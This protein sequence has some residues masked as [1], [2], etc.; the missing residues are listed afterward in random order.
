VVA[1]PPAFRK[2]IA[3]ALLAALLRAEA[4]GKVLADAAAMRARM[5]RDHPPEGPW[6]VKHLPGGLVEVEFLAQALQ[7]A[8]G[9]P[10]AT[11]TAQALAGLA[12]AGVLPAAEAALLAEAGE[13]WL[14]VSGLLRLTVGK[15]APEALPAP[16]IE[17]LLTATRMPDQ[18]A[19]RA[20]MARLAAEVRQVFAR[21][22]GQV[23]PEA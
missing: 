22:L 15:A 4:P 7:L 21:R 11:N 8:H 10:F 17:A 1:G 6:D 14:A 18:A 23:A 13:L 20:R 16:V 2:R 9:G 12:K 3:E 19:L 5:L